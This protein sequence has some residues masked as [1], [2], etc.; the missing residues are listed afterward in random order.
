MRQ[1]EIEIGGEYA[2]GSY[3]GLSKVRVVEKGVAT[4]SWR[5]AK[6]DGVRVEHVA[7]TPLR[8]IRVVATRDMALWEAKHDQRLE[9]ERLQAERIERIERIGG[10]LNVVVMADVCGVVRLHDA[11][12]FELAERL[13]V[14]MD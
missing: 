10:R 4:H 1:T 9:R 11:D 3:H 2:W 14:G 8:G 13:G 5:G 7:G 12:F 6:K